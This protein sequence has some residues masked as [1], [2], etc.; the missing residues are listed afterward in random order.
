[1]GLNLKVFSANYKL[2]TTNYKVK[3]TVYDGKIF[4]ATAPY[5]RDRRPAACELRDALWASPTNAACGAVRPLL[6][7]KKIAE[8][9]VSLCK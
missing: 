5:E 8:K 7:Y 1:M 2:C 9:I 4:R 3:G 6:F